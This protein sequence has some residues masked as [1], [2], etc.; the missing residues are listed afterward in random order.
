[1]TTTDSMTVGHVF[2]IYA[3]VAFGILFVGE[4]HGVEMRVIL[5]DS[6]TAEEACVELS[7]R[8]AGQFVAA[9]AEL[10]DIGLRHYA[11]TGA[12]LTL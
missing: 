10:R 6:L 2:P 12:A 11:R 1:M 3:G 4:S 7:S 5:L 8:F 9:G